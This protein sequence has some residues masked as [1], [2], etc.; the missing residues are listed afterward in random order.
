MFITS[1]VMTNCNWGTKV[2]NRQYI[3]SCIKWRLIYNNLELS[4]NITIKWKMA[5]TFSK[6][7]LKKMKL[8][9]CVAFCRFIHWRLNLAIWTLVAFQNSNINIT[10]WNWIW[11]HNGNKS[12][13]VIRNKKIR[14][15]RNLVH[16]KNIIFRYLPLNV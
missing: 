5:H 14:I 2:F 8:K 7:Y 1:E 11:L 16:L 12:L 3:Y 13:L 10:E 6:M 4:T 9:D 15:T